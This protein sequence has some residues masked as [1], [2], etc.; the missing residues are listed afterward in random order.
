[1]S[2]S[3]ILLIKVDHSPPLPLI[4]APPPPSHLKHQEI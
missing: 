3:Q 1:V 4:E 2:E